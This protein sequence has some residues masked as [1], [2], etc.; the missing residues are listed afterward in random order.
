M[1]VWPV[2]PAEHLL[3]C[4]PYQEDALPIFHFSPSNPLFSP[5]HAQVYLCPYLT[6]IDTD[7]GFV[8]SAVPL[9]SIKQARVDTLYSYS[10]LFTLS[11]RTVT[12]H[13][14]SCDSSSHI[15]SDIPFALLL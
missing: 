6:L 13:S 2:S 1:G 5:H 4:F 14:L 11:L 10:T 3:L 9:D 15:P 12:I 8:S 7:P